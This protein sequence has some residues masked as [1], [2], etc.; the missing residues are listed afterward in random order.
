MFHIDHYRR[1]AVLILLTAAMM[2]FSGRNASADI[3]WQSG[4]TPEGHSYHV[5][6]VPSEAIKIAAS[7]AQHN[8]LAI[9]VAFPGWIWADASLPCR[10][11]PWQHEMKHL[12]GWSHDA[13][14]RWTTKTDVAFAEGDHPR[15]PWTVVKT[16]N[17]YAI[18]RGT[19]LAALPDSAD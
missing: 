17:D 2:F 15:T 5:L 9:A 3:C 12:D 13:N 7:G 14:G 10:I 19:E 16:E 1:A 8:Y 11:I 6:Y 18:V 4:I